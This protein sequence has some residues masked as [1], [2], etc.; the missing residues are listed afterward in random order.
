MRSVRA[1]ACAWR[2]QASG[3]SGATGRLL[4]GGD[5]AAEVARE[6]VGEREVEQAPAGPGLARALE[7]LATPRDP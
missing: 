6:V 3:D 1:S 2:V 7:R 5:L 4:D